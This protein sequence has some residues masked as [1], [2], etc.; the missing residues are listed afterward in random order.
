VREVVGEFGLCSVRGGNHSLNF[1][2]DITKLVIITVLQSITG[3]YRILQGI[4]GFYRVLHGFKGYYTVLQDITRYYT[5][6]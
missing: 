6:Y 2:T 5:R 4:T 1:C 3:Y